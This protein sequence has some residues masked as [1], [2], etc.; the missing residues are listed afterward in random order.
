M[1]EYHAWSK[2]PSFFSNFRIALDTVFFLSHQIFPS[3][4]KFAPLSTIFPLS[5]S[6]F[7]LSL[8][9]FC[10]S[11]Y[12]LSIDFLLIRQISLTNFPLSSFP[13]TKF[14]LSLLTFPL[15]YNDVNP[16]SLRLPISLYKIPSEQV[17]P[18][19]SRI[20][21]FNTFWI[22]PLLKNLPHS[23]QASFKC[24]FLWDIL[25]L[26]SIPTFAPSFFDL[27]HFPFSHFWSSL[28]AA[29]LGASLDR[30]PY[31]NPR[32]RRTKE[33]SGPHLL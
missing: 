5:L 10:L 2:V 7:P 25:P 31:H 33:P 8:N 23:N 22:Y 14:P 26:P 1:S 17:S 13:S 11:S 15:S 12:P 16:L 18:S 4:L 28:P 32:L 29:S 21:T 30:F 19:T 24:F 3:F 6:S 27:I 9:E 20:S